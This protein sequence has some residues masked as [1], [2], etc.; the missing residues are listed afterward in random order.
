MKGFMKTLFE[1]KKPMLGIFCLFQVVFFAFPNFAKAQGVSYDSLRIVV[2]TNNTNLSTLTMN[3]NQDTTLKVIGLRSDTASWEPVNATWQI[4]TGLQFPANQAPPGSADHWSFSPNAPGTGRIRV[5]LGNDAVTKP[6]TVLVIFT[7]G[8]PTGIQITTAISPDSIIAGDTIVAMIINM[9]NKDGLVPGTWCDSTTYQNALGGLVGH[10]PIVIADTTTT[11]GK[12]QH[13]CFS[14]GVDTVRFVLYKAPYSMDSLDKI[15]IAMGSLVAVSDPFRVH[16][17]NLSRIAIE[18]FQGQNLD[19]VFMNYPTGSKLMIAS[20][21]DTFGNKIGPLQTTTWT[22]DGTLHAVTSGGNASRIYYEASQSVNDEAGHIIATAVDGAGSKITDSVY[23]NIKGPASIFP[24][25]QR[26]TAP[27]LS[28]IFRNSQSFVFPLSQ[29]LLRSD[30]SLSLY[31]LSGRV[32]CRIK[33]LDITK[34]IVLNSSIHPGV[35]CMRL[36]AEG[37]TIMQRRLLIAR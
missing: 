16:P 33:N 4:S 3:T 23:V 31:D 10:D 22:T 12:A 9:V 36:C 2:G 24:H 29:S 28:L 15:T 19:T 30:F 18:D 17:G 7:P 20:G 13:E 27:T 25:P 35:C 34:P 1:L 32:V 6:D 14:N 37:K 21:Y 5:T 8:P 11:M 26:P